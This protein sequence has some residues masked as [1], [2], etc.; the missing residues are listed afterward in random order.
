VVKRLRRRSLVGRLTRGLDLVLLVVL[1]LLL[2]VDVAGAS[3]NGGLEFLVPLSGLVTIVAVAM[4]RRALESA[5]GA[6]VLCSLGVTFLGSGERIDYPSAAAVAGMLVLTTTA[7][8]R[9]PRPILFLYVP[10]LGV[11]LAGEGGR[12]G[13]DT[14]DLVFV[15]LFAIAVAAGGYLRW[16]DFQRQQAAAE[17]RRDE[18][19]DLARELHD[20]V[21]HYVTGIV[22][23]AQAAQVVAEQQPMAAR[24][25]LVRIEQ[26]GTDALTAMRRMVGSLRSDDADANATAETTQPPA[27]WAGL[28]ELVEQHN[29]VGVPARLQLEGVDTDQLPAPV[30]ASI[31]RIVLESLTNVRRHA[32]DVTTVDVVARRRGDEVEIVVRDDGSTAG[33]HSGLGGIG[34]F[35]LVGMSE[36][37]A[38]LG[39]TLSAGPVEDGPGWQVLARLPLERSQ[40]T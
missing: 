35:G 6:A 16:L 40:L 1:G 19:L 38:A 36:R 34:G 11:A 26:A 28:E 20:L 31:H 33:R 18:R 30:A 2:L 25:A 4:R 37:A 7:T 29:A 24:D 32:L 3:T 22:V 15:F 5:V 13:G 27:G 21:A 12:P 17:A 8:R 23:Q 10:A 14:V 39:G 9:L